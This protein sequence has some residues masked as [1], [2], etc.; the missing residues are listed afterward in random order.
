MPGATGRSTARAPRPSLRVVAAPVADRSRT[1]FVVGCLLLLV[2][3]LFGLLLINISL[4]QGSFRLHDLQA[5]SRQ[6]SDT[7]QA[8][9]EDIALQ[10]SPGQLSVRAAGLGMVPSGSV[11]FL[12]LPDG[13][14][15]G[16]AKPAP[17]A[18]APT[19]APAPAGTAGAQPGT[20][21]PADKPSSDKPSS[22]AAGAQATPGPSADPTSSTR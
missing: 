10:A 11:A 7:S 4:A 17:A 1:A 13:R 6:L 2:G 21:E 12:R 8:L 5:Q 20:D 14:V 22:D 3:G 18:A 15:L 9:R 16:V 19:V